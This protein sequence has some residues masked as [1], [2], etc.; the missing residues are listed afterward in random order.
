MKENNFSY[1]ETLNSHSFLRRLRLRVGE[2]R[3]DNE[4]NSRQDWFNAEV[5][6]TD[7]EFLEQQA[8]VNIL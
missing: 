2:L 7:A 5:G 6:E 3:F 1:K 8:I 4:L